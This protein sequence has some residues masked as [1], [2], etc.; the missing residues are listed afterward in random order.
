M[1]DIQI[2][3]DFYVDV[4]AYQWILKR[5]VERKSKQEGKVGEK[6]DAFIQEGFYPNIAA[7]CSRVVKELVREGVA[8]GELKTLT[9]VI[10]RADE[11]ERNITNAIGTKV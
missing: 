2:Y 3:G 8:K 9:E 5:K 4:D 11:L 6:Y 10:E 7:A 1:A